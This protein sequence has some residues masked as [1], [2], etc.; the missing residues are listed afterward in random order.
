VIRDWALAAADQQLQ[1][2]VAVIGGGIAGL[3]CAH[4]LAARGQQVVVLESGDREQRSETHPW[5]AVEQRGQVYAG[6]EHGRFRCLGGSSTRWGGAMLPFLPEDVGAHTAGWGPAWGLPLETLLRHLPEIEQLFGLPAGAY[7]ETSLPGGDAAGY[8]ARF[9]KWPPFRMRNVALLLADTLRAEA[10]PAVWLNACVTAMPLDPAGQL[11][12]IEARNRAGRCLEVRAR[13]YLLAA[14]ALESTRLLL[15]LD[16]AASDRVFA[17]DQVIGR[18]LNDHLSAPIAELLPLDRN[19]FNRTIGFR[20]EQGG[21]RNL[22]FELRE[23]SR[24]PAQLPAS[25]THIAFESAGPDGFE[26]L[27][28]VYRALQKG[29]AP[30]A[31]SLIQLARHAPWLAR[32]A[33]WRYGLGRL[34]YPSSG[35]YHAHLVIEQQPRPENRITLSTSQEDEFGLPRACIDWRVGEADRQNFAALAARF[36]AMW[37][38]SACGALATLEPLPAAR[39]SAALAEGGGVFHPGGTLRIGAGPREGVVDQELRCHRIPNLRVISTAAFPT[40]G[41]ANPTLMLM[42]YARHV[43]DRLARSTA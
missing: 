7:E 3:L 19:R 4:W 17:A 11:A 33:W 8:I 34:L 10:G 43:I 5:N 37:P 29:R 14:G 24:S 2:D 41:G 23:P 38:R 12:G 40:V 36:Q 22:R 31:A 13:H 21:M 6:A 39:W 26:A 16:R 42:L 20:F 9:A 15:L 1:A 27:R 18:H 25:F 32:A 28:A 35:R 30:R